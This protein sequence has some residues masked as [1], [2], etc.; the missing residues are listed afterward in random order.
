MKGDS[1]GIEIEINDALDESFA[2]KANPVHSVAPLK[3]DAHCDGDDDGSPGAISNNKVLWLQPRTKKL[4]ATASV[5]VFFLSICIGIGIRSR[6]RM[7]PPQ[8]A[9]HWPFRVAMVLLRGSLVALNLIKIFGEISA[10][11]SS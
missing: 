7:D 10:V 11:T 4:A 8:Q 2:R 5:F 6:T 3:G 9:T 1:A